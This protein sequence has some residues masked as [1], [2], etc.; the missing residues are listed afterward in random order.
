M[1]GEPL[2]GPETTDA[3]FSNTIRTIVKRLRQRVPAR[4]GRPLAPAVRSR[5][6]DDAPPSFGPANWLTKT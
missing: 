6:C 5:G 1:S 4:K 3:A 2:A